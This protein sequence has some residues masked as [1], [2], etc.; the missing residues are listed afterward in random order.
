MS[1]L[2]DNVLD[3]VESFVLPISLH[4]TNGIVGTQFIL[5][6]TWATIGLTD[7]IEIDLTFDRT[8]L[9]DDEDNFRVLHVTGKLPQQAKEDP[10]Y[11]LLCKYDVDFN[12]IKQ[13]FL[14]IQYSNAWMPHDQD[15]AGMC[16]EST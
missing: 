12:K 7:F 14:S 13:K 3:M 2:Q 9:S 4:E 1:V 5:G 16:C 11:L 15:H 8:R 6:K 10:N